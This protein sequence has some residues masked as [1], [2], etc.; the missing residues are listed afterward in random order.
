M[1][2]L[3]FLLKLA[4]RDSKRER[5]KLLMFMSSIILGISALV[6]I[7]SFN[8]NLIEDIDDQSKSL[9]GADLRISGNKDLD[10]STSMILDSLPG[11]SSIEKELFS[12]AFFPKNEESQF[13]RIKSIDGAF[14]YY[15]NLAVKPEEASKKYQQN[16]AIVDNGLMIE[17]SLELGDS[18]R[19][20][21]KMIPIIGRL[22]SDFGS[23]GLGSSF[24]PSV[25]INGAE[26][27]ETNL[28]QPGSMI[29][30][31]YHFK[32]PSSY[33]LREWN[34]VHRKTF[35]D[36]GYRVTLIEDQRENLQEAFSSLNS[37]L[38]LIALVSLILGCL[39]V[40]SSVFIYV[41]SKIPTIATFRCLGLNPNQSFLVYF[42]QIVGFGVIS[43]FLG[44]FIGSAI[45]L[46]LPVVLSDL[47]PYQVDMQ[48]SWKAI[49]EGL[50]IGVI[51]SI[52]F[53]AIPLLDI[54]KISPLR[55]LRS[56]VEEV[57]SSGIDLIKSLVYILI[58]ASLI[59]FMYSLTGQWEDAIVLVLGIALAFLVL[60]GLAFLLIFLVK[61]FFPR[62]WSFVFRQGISNLFRP[63][64]QTRTLVVSIG[65]GTAILTTLFIIQGLLLQNVDS[66]DA[67]NQPNMILYGIESEQ[68]KDVREITESFD[69]P[70]IQEV[71][72]VTMR[73]AGW[74]GRTKDE[75]MKD[76]TRTARRWVINR[77]ARVTYRDYLEDD[78]EILEG[79][80]IGSVNPGD[81][82][83]ISLSDTY[84]DNL[85][86]GI[87]D[88]LVWNVQGSLVTTYIS[89]IRKIEFRS[90]RTRFFVLFPNG[91]LEAAPQF[92]V[93]V[94]KAPNTEIMANYRRSVVKSLPNVSV[95]DLASILSTLNGI[96]SKIS[97][98]IKFM[99]AF[100]ILTGL[101]VLISSL[102]L[103]KF[104]RIRESVLLRTIGATKDKIYKI[105]VT[106]YF[107]LGSLSAASGIV[108][109]IIASFLI[110]TQEL[111]LDFSL[112][113][114]PIVLIFLFIVSLTI[115]IGLY[116]SREIVNKAPLEVLRKEI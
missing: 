16:G 110:T 104:Q 93:L 22:M 88:E 73:L 109:S 19:L 72:I 115:L 36:K 102:L 51:V 33:E 90:M 34:D 75:W 114:W 14:P 108:L 1:S 99:A 18:I 101:I 67:G 116:N 113:W 35:R 106:E 4:Y 103:S 50:A 60:S 39:G 43:V 5:P 2:Q 38:N 57:K 41:K 6:A 95:V 3:P 84:A 12:M 28:V 46:L 80:F 74:K 30:Y 78:E 37:F 86:V 82:I 105:N 89:S 66:M 65:L 96:L 54:R 92:H 31:A 55:T 23:I 87:G 62:N 10:E 49:L 13:V 26:L 53:A 9:L 70:V 45:Q 56:S 24:A 25:Y 47:L 91:V 32:I 27:I 8:Y 100:S 59:L 69:L 17:Q 63:N 107:I 58:P 29:D 85:D 111:E 44:A 77:E 76:T 97:Y 40:A 79:E 21:V 94:T 98:V 61:R 83:F 64:N 42:F 112:N 20:G 71:P 11:E 81:S 52:L 15:G 7:N 48:L 68:T